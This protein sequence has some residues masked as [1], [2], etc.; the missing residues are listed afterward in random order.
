MGQKLN[1]TIICFMGQKLNCTIIF[2]YSVQFCCLLGHV[3]VLVVSLTTDP[4]KESWI[5]VCG[6]G[7][8]TNFGEGSS[9]QNNF[10]HSKWL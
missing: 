3:A 2:F 10:Q 9:G 4:G 5:P 1:C 6:G 7:G 8:G